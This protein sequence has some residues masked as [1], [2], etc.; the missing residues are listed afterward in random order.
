MIFAHKVI[1]VLWIFQ[2]LLRARAIETQCYVL[3]AA[4]VGAHHKKRSSYGHTLAVDPWGVVIA[5]CG[6]TD[7]GV[8]MVEIDMDR[9]QDTRRDMPVQQHRREKEFYCSLDRTD[10][11]KIIT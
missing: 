11:Q 5:D 2:V 10:T 3:A 8:A 1:L 6:G 9:L 4:Q 7:V